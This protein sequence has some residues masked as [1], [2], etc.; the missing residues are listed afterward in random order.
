MT[1]TF[2]RCIGGPYDG[3]TIT[4]QGAAFHMD[5]Y[6]GGGTLGQA[7][8]QPGRASGTYIRDDGTYFWHAD[9]PDDA[10]MA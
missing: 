1:S 6:P 2:W 7:G 5:G 8:Y 3:I 9:P 4:D 10:K